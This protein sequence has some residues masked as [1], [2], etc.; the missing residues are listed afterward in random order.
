MLQQTVS[1]LAPPPGAHVWLARGRT[2]MR[3]GFDGLAALAQLQ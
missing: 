2:D 3:E 1:A